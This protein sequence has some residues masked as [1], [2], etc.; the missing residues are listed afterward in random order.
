MVLVRDNTIVTSV[1]GVPVPTP[2]TPNGIVFGWFL[3]MSGGLD[4][5]RNI[6]YL[7]AN[8]AIRLV[9]KVLQESAGDRVEIYY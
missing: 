2:G 5:Q 6:K 1:E 4:P 3:D 8:N 9:E 7:I